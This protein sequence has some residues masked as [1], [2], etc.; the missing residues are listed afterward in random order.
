MVADVAAVAAAVAV[1]PADVAAM[2]SG[3]SLDMD[4]AGWAVSVSIAL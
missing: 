2:P 1:A 3:Q 4:A